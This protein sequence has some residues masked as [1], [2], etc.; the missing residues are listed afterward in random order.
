MIFLSKFHFLKNVS[1]CYC[2][3]ASSLGSDFDVRFPFLCKFPVEFSQFCVVCFWIFCGFD[4]FLSV[5]S[6]SKVPLDCL[7]SIC[8]LLIFST[9]ACN[10][11]LTFLAL[12][13]FGK[14]WQVAVQIFC[15]ILSPR[16][17]EL[18]CQVLE[19]PRLRDEG[20]LLSFP[21]QQQ[22]PSTPRGWLW[23]VL[24]LRVPEPSASCTSVPVT[25]GAPSARDVR[26]SLLSLG[27]LLRKSPGLSSRENFQN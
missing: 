4:V 3:K 22:Q 23:C 26:F 14:A 7:G 2:S 20:L 12:Q 11:F 15:A 24:L 21:R 18:F 25:F 10:S 9:Q 17:I 5:L 6:F 19:G 13:D 27:L 1:T 8:G 16:I